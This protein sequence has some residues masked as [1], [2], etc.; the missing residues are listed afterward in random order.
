MSFS[1]DIQTVEGIL[2][3]SLKG[4]VLEDKILKDFLKTIDTALTKTKGKVILNLSELDYVNSTGIN[5]FIKV[6]TKA[7]IHGGDLVFYGITGS[8]QTIVHI[9]KM[10]EVFTIVE[11]QEEALSIFKATK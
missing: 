1:T 4:K 3:V 11:S 5:F 6:L 7:R 8:V 10:D 9:S 2:V